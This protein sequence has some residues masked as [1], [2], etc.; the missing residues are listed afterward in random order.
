M[1]GWSRAVE[2]ISCAISTLLRSAPAL[3]S[4][5]NRS[6]LG[7]VRPAAACPLLLCSNSSSLQQAQN[8]I[9]NELFK[10]LSFQAHVDA[11]L[12]VTHRLQHCS[13]QRGALFTIIPVAPGTRVAATLAIVT[14]SQAQEEQRQDSMIECSLLHA[15]VWRVAAAATMWLQGHES[16]QQG[17]LAEVHDR[18]ASAEA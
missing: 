11:V 15:D 3:A 4:I 16:S 12:Q 7:C 9:S 2:H 6:E 8:C 5:I 13:P 10:L 14:R 18:L 17:Q 1:W